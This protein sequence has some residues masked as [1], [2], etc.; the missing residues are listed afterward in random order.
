M[1]VLLW[2]ICTPLC[3]CWAVSCG[4]FHTPTCSV[5]AHCTTHSYSYAANSSEGCLRHSIVLSIHTYNCAFPALKYLD[6][7][8]S[9]ILSSVLTLLLVFNLYTLLVPTFSGV[10]LTLNAICTFCIHTIRHVLPTLIAVCILLA[11]HALLLCTHPAMCIW[12]Q[13]LCG[14]HACTPLCTP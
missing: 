4:V 11:I 2:T 7:L 8:L 6:T 14:V 3:V 1:S 5:L 10:L 12:H 9:H 13:M